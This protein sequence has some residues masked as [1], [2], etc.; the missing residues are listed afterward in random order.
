MILMLVKLATRVPMVLMMQ[1]IGRDDSDNDGADRGAGVRQV[2]NGPL[3]M[4]FPLL[5]LSLIHI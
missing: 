5:L 2:D 4:G 3:I 1:Y